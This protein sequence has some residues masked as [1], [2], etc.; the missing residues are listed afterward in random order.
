MK[1]ILVPTDF[2]DCAIKAAK[3]AAYVA[4]KTDAMVHLIHVYERPLYHIQEPVIDSK[5]NTRILNHIE[6][7][8]ESMETYEFFDGIKIKSHI[9]PDVSITEIVENERF[10]DADLIIMGSHGASGW[11]EMLIGSNT[12]KVVRTANCPVLTIKN[13]NKPFKADNIVFASTFYTEVESVFHKIKAFADIFDATIHLVKIVTRTHFETTLLSHKLMNDFAAK[14][15]LKKF[16]INTFNDDDLENGIIHFAEHIDADMISLTTHGR[17][18]IAHILNGSLAEDVVNHVNRP[19]LSM[20]IK[21]K[22]VKYGVIF[23]D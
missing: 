1:N 21:E 20:K 2:S 12:E 15:K 16:T 6:R 3:V 18:G 7:E 17:T 19:V 10:E 9:L 22:K 13:L 14:F 23:P 11:K 4:K 5:E 8:L